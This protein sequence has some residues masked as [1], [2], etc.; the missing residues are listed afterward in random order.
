[1]PKKSIHHL[2]I[3]IILIV[4]IL[5]STCWTMLL[6]LFFVFSFVK[7]PKLCWPRTF[8]VENLYWTLHVT[9]HTILP[10]SPLIPLPSSWKEL[11]CRLKPPKQASSR[12][13]LP[14]LPEEAMLLWGERG[15]WSGA[16]PLAVRRSSWDSHTCP[17]GWLLGPLMGGVRD[18]ERLSGLC[19]WLPLPLVKTT[20]QKQD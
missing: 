17:R 16:G 15:A 6:L 11:R 2:I 8:C 20:R 4:K 3:T 1:M 18:T 10:Y 13:S 7:E 14:P 5:A 19:C 12:C 9:A